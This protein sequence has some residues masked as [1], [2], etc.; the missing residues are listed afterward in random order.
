[1]KWWTNSPR[2][3]LNRSFQGN[4]KTLYQKETKQK[5]LCA[6]LHN[7]KTARGGLWVELH[8]EPCF[9]GSLWFSPA[10]VLLPPPL[11]LLFSSAWR[12]SGS[13][14]A[15]RCQHWEVLA[16]A[17]RLADSQINHSRHLKCRRTVQELSCLWTTDANNKYDCEYQHEH[18]NR[19]LTLYPE[20]LM[21]TPLFV[22]V[23]FILM[24]K[25]RSRVLSG[26][27]RLGLLDSTEE[28]NK[29]HK[30]LLHLMSSIIFKSDYT[31]FIYLF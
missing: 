28:E 21:C 6:S 27:R 30:P 9:T 11:L 3:T 19:T 18:G 2:W 14:S 5:H 7:S 1:M 15:T 17:N 22:N 23:D 13:T 29:T 10:Y 24:K 31:T 20:D 16:K 25:D 26:A 8:T 4:R 12:L